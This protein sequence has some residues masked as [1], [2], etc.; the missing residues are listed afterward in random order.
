MINFNDFSAVCPSLTCPL[1]GCLHGWERD[2]NGCE[3]CYCAA[4]PPPCPF[5]GK[6]RF[7]I[8]CLQIAVNNNNVH[9]NSE[10]DRLWSNLFVFIDY[11]VEDCPHGYEIDSNGCQTCNCKRGPKV[12]PLVMCR[13]HCEH[14]WA[15]DEITG[16]NICACAP[17]P[18]PFVCQPVM[19][20]MHCEHGWAKDE[21]TGCNICAC[22]PP[23]DSR[24][25]E[26]NICDGRHVSG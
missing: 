13:M 22:A 19:C 18:E 16:C 17:P 23:P 20:R 24:P 1:I 5:I 4:E 14:G 7:N 8:V 2:E 26:Q 3:L 25:G 21:I 6:Y 9:T 12:C 10:R 15:K 11:C